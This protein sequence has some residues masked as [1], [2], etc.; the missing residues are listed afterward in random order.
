MNGVTRRRVVAVVVSAA[1]VLLTGAVLSSG[2]AVADDGQHG[3]DG[4]H[5]GKSTDDPRPENHRDISAPLRDITPIAPARGEN[6]V[7]NEYVMR[8]PAT[9]TGA[10]DT[11][12]QAAAGAA[13]APT[14]G[15]SFEGVG[16]GFTGPAGTFTVN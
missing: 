16:Q 7:K 5:V 10:P 13:A 1:L 9:G 14:L 8:P 4:Q 2:A 6:K 11:A 15:S 12:L 3:F